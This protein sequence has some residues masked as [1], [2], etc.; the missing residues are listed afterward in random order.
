MKGQEA[1][2][3]SQI[4]QQPTESIRMPTEIITEELISRYREAERAATETWRYRVLTYGPDAA[5]LVLQ[6][7]DD[8]GVIVATL[9][10]GIAAENP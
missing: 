6:S 10:P 4:A 2:Q 1:E 7:F 8:L 3:S 5:R 9:G